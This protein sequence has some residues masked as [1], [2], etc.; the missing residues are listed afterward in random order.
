M[1]LCGTRAGLPLTRREL[2]Q[3][4]SAGFG[5]LAL[6]GLLAHDAMGATKAPP[7]PGTAKR[8]IFL[9]MHGGPS[10]V[11]LFDPKPLLTRDNGKTFPL[12]APRI[13][14]HPTKNLLLQSPWSCQ[15]HGQSGAQVCE[16]LPH[17]ASIAD[18]LCFMKSMHCSNSCHGG[19]LL[20][21]H[22]GSDT[23]VRP[24]MGSWINYGL[25]SEN[26]NLPGFITINPSGSH[27][28]DGA[29]SSAFLRPNTAAPPSA[30]K[31]R[32]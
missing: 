22:T 21:L 25:G 2:L 30:E 11:D 32:P 16:L 7:L 4:S 29:W 12:K 1:S 5:A 14:S 17:I 8:V 28:G 23:F 15:Q 6:Q 3:T 26:A 19:A 9:F 18:D 20:E 10:T 27:G 24:S 31:A 13:T